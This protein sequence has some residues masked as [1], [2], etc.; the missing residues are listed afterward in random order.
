[1]SAAD[2]QRLLALVPELQRTAKEEPA[3]TADEARMVI[4]QVRAEIFQVLGSERPLTEELFL[5]EMT[6]AAYLE[7]P[8]ETRARL[9]DDWA[10]VDLEELEEL[11]VHANAV[12]AE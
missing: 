11:D 5:N 7:L 12:P 9:W 1:M 6:L 3:R 8:D 2:R 4:E 10:E